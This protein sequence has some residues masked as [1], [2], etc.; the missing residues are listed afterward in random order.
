MLDKYVS[1]LDRYCTL[2]L[3]D[4]II[5]R[6]YDYVAIILNES[7]EIF[8]I[9]G[10]VLKQLTEEKCKIYQFFKH[11]FRILMAIRKCSEHDHPVCCSYCESNKWTTICGWVSTSDR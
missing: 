11:I 5:L 2:I 6:N 4:S 10:E 3:N 7:G 8:Q 9:V 1:T